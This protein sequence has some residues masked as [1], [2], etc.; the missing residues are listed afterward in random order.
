[1]RI[2]IFSPLRNGGVK[3]FSE[4]L[5]Q[6]FSILGYDSYIVYGIN[7]LFKFILYSRSLNFY[8]ISSIEGGFFSIFFKK[9]IFVLHGF[10]NR[11]HINFFRFIFIYLIT[12]L[13]SFLS[14]NVVSVSELTKHI[15]A[16]FFSINSDFSIHNCVDIEFINKPINISSKKNKI[17]YVGRFVSGKNINLIIES[18]INFCF[19]NNKYELHIVGG[20]F[21]NNLLSYYKKYPIFIH[22]HISDTGTLVDFYDSSSIFISLNPLEPF[23]ITFAEAFCRNLKIIAPSTGGQREF[24]PFDP[25]IVFINNVNS[26]TEIS[27]AFSKLSMVS[28]NLLNR[29]S[30]IEYFSPTR[31][32]ENYL[33]I[34]KNI[35]KC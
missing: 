18:F 22:D 30:F 16:S 23:G 6:G 26:I 8:Y 17:L 34:M 29:E 33:N 15:N 31:M 14:T 32:A 20:K 35:D 28:D 13:F 24:L 27:S 19:T 3:R 9:S 10:P 11:N 21:D 2:I 5:N 1:M 25:G 7:E 4:S 12:K